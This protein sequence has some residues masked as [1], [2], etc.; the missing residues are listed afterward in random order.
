MDIIE[1][2]ISDILDT[3]GIEL[4]FLNGKPFSDKYKSLATKWSN[5]PMY[6]DVKV[7]KQFFNLLHTKQVILLVSGTGSGKTVVVPKFVLKYMVS[8]GLKGKIAITNPKILTTVYNAEYGAI[9]LDVKLGE[10]VGYKYKG[11]PSNSIGPNS[12]LLYVT[13]GLILA[14]ILS[15]DSVLSQYQGIIIDE[16]HERHVQIDVLLCLLKEVLYKRP[17]FKLIIMSA[18]INA[19]V[20]RNY[21]MVPSI[22][23]GEMEVSGESNHP[24]KQNWLDPT[25]KINKGNYLDQAVNKAFDI[26]NNSTD[27]DIIVFVPTQ[28]DAI[29]GCQL[30]NKNCPKSLKTTNTMC[31]KLYCVEVF[32]KMKQSNK[33]LAVSKDMYKKKGFNRKIIFATNVAESSIT[34]DGLVYV[35]ETGYELANYY[36][37]SDNSYVISKEYTSKA[38]VKQR[39]GRAG[40]TQ[41]GISYHLYKQSDFDSFKPYPEPTIST[42]DIVDFVLGFIKYTKTI[43]FLIPLIKGM[44]TIP[45]LEQIVGSIYKLH[46]IKC[47]KIIDQTDSTS[48]DSTSTTSTDSTSTDS[49]STDSTDSTSTDADLSSSIDDLSASDDCIVSLTKSVNQINWA[50]MRN[51]NKIN[52]MI[53]GTTTILGATILKFKSSPVLS[54]LSII[55]AKYLDCQDQMIQL[56]ALIEISDGKLESFLSY[57]RKQETDTVIKY[58]SKYCK[59]QSD[60][61]NI[62]CIYND[63]YKQN[64]SKY[65]NKKQ[66]SLV[67]RRIEQLNLYSRSIS[68]DTYQR[69]Q[70]K[71]NLIKKSQSDEDIANPES[72]LLYILAMSHYYNM[73]KK[74]GKNI[75]VSLHYLNNS[76]APVEYAL[77]TPKP[78]IN[79]NYVISYSLTNVFGNKSFQCISQIPDNII[80]QIK[81]LEDIPFLDRLS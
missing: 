52:E 78:D 48:T 19:E 40:R 5:L 30:L 1:K 59:S 25:I 68:S 22:K 12:K 55:M 77:F 50:K 38:Q 2:N 47:L 27:G 15:G 79:T 28:N 62:L 75:Y 76:T 16:A 35:I 44:I 37:A 20:F 26:L 6:K 14:T 36:D 74:E 4:N 58:F 71:Y 42:T 33:D 41:P 64:K 32:S 66:L 60:H 10:E 65:L 29:K 3:K 23:Y 70:T 69:I 61:L 39:I 43:K 8:M 49:T 17:D 9:T 18:T 45:K 24:I 46:F 63:L 54:A 34:F 53:N 56:M 81:Q 57:D 72:R 31:N 13:D 67:D 11:A 73:L 80:N 7:V 51:L 21:F